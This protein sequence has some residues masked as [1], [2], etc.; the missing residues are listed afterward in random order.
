MTGKTTLTPVDYDPFA[1]PELERIFPPTEPQ[2][3]LWVSAKM[4]G[5]EANASYNESVTLLLR[6]PL[7]VA[8]LRGAFNAV[9]GRHEALRST[10]SPDGEQVCIAAALEI[11]IPVIDLSAA[12]EAERGEGLRRLQGR[13]VEEPFDLEHGPLVRVQI[14]K[15]S[16][17]EHQVVFSAHHIVCDGWSMAVVMQEAGIFYSAAV[18]G[19][20]AALPEA[21][22]FSAYARAEQER[23]QTPEHAA[24]EEYWLRQF[25]GGVPVL[26]LPADYVRPP[27]RTVLSDRVNH[28]VPPSL[29]K[30]MKEAGAREGCSYFITMM[31]AFQVLVY[32]LTGQT[33]MVVGVPAAGQSAAGGDLLVGH[34]VNFL[35]VLCR[36]DP[37]QSFTA[38]LLAQ[39]SVLF[40]A[41]DHQQITAGTL[42]NRLPIHRDPSRMPL[43]TVVFNIDQK[44]EGDALPFAELEADI[45]SN[46]HPYASFEIGID[47]V[48]SSAG[49]VFECQYNTD[50]FARDTIRHW[51]RCLEQL[52]ATAAE[53]P[54]LP[55]R[56]MPLLQ[57]DDKRT[58]IEE[59]GSSAATRA[60]GECAHHPFEKQAARTPERTALVAADGS[61]T[62]RE[63]DEKASRIAAHLSAVTGIG[64]EDRVGVLA[65]RTVRA[66]AAILGVL[67]A[68]GAY[69][70]MDPNSPAERLRY[71]VED[72]G[73]RCILADPGAAASL[74]DMTGIEILN[75]ETLTG[76]PPDGPPPA[77]VVNGGSLAYII[78]TSGSTG[79]P[80]GVMIEHRSVAN[81]VSWTQAVIYSVTGTG[82]NEAMVSPFI[83]DVSV[84]QLFGALAAGNTLHFVP[85]DV[86]ED[87]WAFREFLKE[88]RIDLLNVTPSLLE[89]LLASVE[90]LPWPTPF[91]D[92]GAE[93]LK[94]ETLR[95]FFGIPG[96]RKIV[97]HNIY[98]PTECCVDATCY[99]VD[100][101]RLPRGSIVPIG[102][103]VSNLKVFVLDGESQLAPAGVRGEICV[104][105]VGLARGYVSEAEGDSPFVDNPLQPGERMYRTGD[106]GRWNA[107]GQLEF[108]GRRD[109]QVK[110]RGYRVELGE[111]E[112]RLQTHP[113][114]ARG[115]VALREDRPGDPRLICYVVPKEGQ[116]L[117][118]TVLRRHLRDSLPAYMIP[119]HL[120]EVADLP[121]TASGK[122]DRRRLP[123]PFILRDGREEPPPETE[124]EKMLAAIWRDVLNSGD[125]RADDNFFDLGGH[126]LSC[127]QVVARIEDETGVRLRPAVVLLNSLRQTA[128]RIDEA[129]ETQG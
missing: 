108:F 13:S 128:A 121:L 49:M 88:Q 125:I 26:D 15:L 52:M 87:G 57:D 36:V 80:K 30:A 43:V 28:T 126:S 34:C 112:S 41:Y 71:M 122:V 78:Y 63:L 93:A 127:M 8:A 99:R 20:S 129:R 48:V 83:F 90:E 70:P 33:E 107:E 111:I 51:M 91:L 97:I 120:V 98:G 45:H 4:G 105:G 66:A 2:R 61:L 21:P 106:I 27:V 86:I 1:S 100:S 31:A 50:L 46:P 65:G 35:P 5:D 96:N 58:M 54:D 72:S 113:D 68:G 123:A 29:V 38:H 101:E 89:A 55:L 22:Q 23:R 94:V 47:A 6:G 85:G 124:A 117:T 73:C 110:I 118:M 53:S 64:P 104:T 115:A 42:L 37:D 25:S 92:I 12:P 59:W 62:Y 67:K 109:G 40:N 95:R 3:E 24:T 9:I 102:R 76:T 103:P 79:R 14:A 74:P 75:V 16:D 119:Q 56:R 19:A 114:V 10:F 32:R 77:R 11:D 18:K 82:I 60:A 39:R 81:M 84:Q 44:A 69:V 7:D 116:R 17:E